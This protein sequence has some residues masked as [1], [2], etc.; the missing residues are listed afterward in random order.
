[1]KMFASDF[2]QG[3]RDRDDQEQEFLESSLLFFCINYLES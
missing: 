3:G 2:K 1:M